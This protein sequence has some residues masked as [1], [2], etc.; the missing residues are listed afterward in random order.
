[1]LETLIPQLRVALPLYLEDVDHSQF[2]KLLG[3]ISVLAGI[4]ATT[5]DEVWNKTIDY[6]DANHPGWRGDEN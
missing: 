6:L 1:M 4:A 3:R 2:P 5:S